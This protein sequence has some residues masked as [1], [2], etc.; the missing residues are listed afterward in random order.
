MEF[1]SHADPSALSRDVVRESLLASGLWTAI[2]ARPYG[3]TAVPDSVPSSIF[4]Q[5]ID[6]NPLAADPAPLVKARPE[7]FRYGLQALSHLTDGP[8][9]LCCRPEAELPGRELEFVRVDEFAGPHPAGLPGTH[10]HFL[11]PVGEGTTVWYL[12]YADVMDIGRFITSGRLPTT[13]VISLA[14]PAVKEPRLVE[15]P[16]GA[17]LDEIIEGELIEGD[18]DVR[19]VSGSVLHGRTS[20]PFFNYL[21]RYATQVTALAEGNVR[22]FLGWQGPGF[23][24]FSVRKIF[25]SAANPFKKFAMSTSTHGSPRAM[26]PIGVYED[27]MPLD[28]EPTYLLRSLIVGDTEQ[29]QKLGGL[30]LEEEDLALCTFVDPGKT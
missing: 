26:V 24:K 25:A 6:T 29:L 23:E 27:I 11:D 5:A 19:V 12:N 28:V 30:E 15:V 21:G 10:I 14:G 18:G 2:R 13:R 17:C 1:E 20:E 8:L 9:H 22:E 16:I 4:V 7:D 3:K